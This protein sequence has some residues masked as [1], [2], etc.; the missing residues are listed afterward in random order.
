M[1]PAERFVVKEKFFS[2]KGIS[3]KT[4]QLLLAAN[5]YS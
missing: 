3:A 1:C 5:R 2:E 4:R